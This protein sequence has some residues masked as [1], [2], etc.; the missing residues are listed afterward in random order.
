MSSIATIT[1]ADGKATPEN[2]VFDPINS[3]NDSLYRTKV[4]TLPLVGQEQITAKIKKINP[5]VSSVVLGIELPALETATDANSSGYT[6]AP[7]VAYVNRITM[8][9]MLPTRGTAAQRTDLRTLAKNLLANA[10]VVDFV[11]NLTPAY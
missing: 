2:H 10:Q 4:S 3:G 6:A 9:F 1:I 5:N 7:K 8:T 11:D